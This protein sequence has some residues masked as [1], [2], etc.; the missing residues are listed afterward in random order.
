V[1]HHCSLTLAPATRR[2][3][4][5]VRGRR[6]ISPSHLTA[7]PKLDAH[8]PNRPPCVKMPCLQAARS[9]KPS[10]A[11]RAARRTYHPTTCTLRPD[12]DAVRSARVR[13][14]RRIPWRSS[15]WR[16]VTRC[17]ANSAA[18]SASSHAG[19]PHPG[20]RPPGRP[21]QPRPAPDRTRSTPPMLRH[22]RRAPPPERTRSTTHRAW[23]WSTRRPQQLPYGREDRRTRVGQ[24]GGAVGSEDEPGDRGTGRPVPTT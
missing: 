1:Q 4:I 19:C 8:P 21:G 17:A 16:T 13:R 2:S 6:L 24:C 11:S 20:L 7:S 9:W 15:S 10:S 18:T 14:T 22:S 12:S 23:L 5:Q 3:D